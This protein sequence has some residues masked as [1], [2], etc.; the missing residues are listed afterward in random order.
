VVKLSHK[1]G[2]LEVGFF[3]DEGGNHFLGHLPAPAIAIGLATQ[4][5]V[6]L[7]GAVLLTLFARFVDRL[8]RLF[9]QDPLAPRLLVVPGA[10]AIALPR[11][12]PAR[13]P[14][15]TRGPPPSAS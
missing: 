11:R 4:A 3:L 12:R 13:G 6:A 10:P 15:S 2:I 7:A 1:H 5:L 8:G 9:R 14:A